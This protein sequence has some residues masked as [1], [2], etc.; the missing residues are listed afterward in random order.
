MS[1]I[2]VHR[3]PEETG[4]LDQPD[5][6]KEGPFSGGQGLQAEEPGDGLGAGQS[7]GGA[8]GVDGQSLADFEKELDEQLDRL[9]EELAERHLPTPAGTAV[10]SRRPASRASGARWASRPST[11]GYASRRC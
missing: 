11:I 4:G 5:G 9:H 8:G 6:G 3:S 7:N 2:P 1:E 10:P